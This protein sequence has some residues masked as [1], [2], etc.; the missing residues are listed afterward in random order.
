LAGGQYP[1]LICSERK[2]LPTGCW[3]LICSEKK[4]CRLISP[5]NGASIA[6]PAADVRAFGY[7]PDEPCSN[8]RG[9]VGLGKEEW[10]YLVLEDFWTW[11]MVTGTSLLSA[12]STRRGAGARRGC[13]LARCSRHGLMRTQWA[14]FFLATRRGP[15]WQLKTSPARGKVLTPNRP[16]PHQKKGL[17]HVLKWPYILQYARSFA[18]PCYCY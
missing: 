1:M 11:I 16:R 12:T 5:A 3:W 14:A 18:S 6:T 13:L 9:G 8:N 17:A 15:G 4:Y 7:G 10:N 2:V